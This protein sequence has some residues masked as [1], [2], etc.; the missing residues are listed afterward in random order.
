M[1]K[2][3]M[4]IFLEEQQIDTYEFLFWTFQE[5]DRRLLKWKIISR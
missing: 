4:K 2:L 1:I 5:P 3:V